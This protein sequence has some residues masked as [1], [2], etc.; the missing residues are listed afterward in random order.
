MRET[1]ILEELRLENLYRNPQRSFSVWDTIL[2]EKL[3]YEP[4]ITLLLNCSCFDAKVSDD[5]IVSVT[6]W[7]TTTQ[8]FHTVYASVFADCSGDAILAPLSGAL[9]RMVRESREEYGESYALP[10]ADSR[11]MGMSCMF[12]AR[13][14]EREVPF[15][16]PSWAY[17]F[18]SCSDLPGGINSHKWLEMGY[19]LLVD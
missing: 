3:R 9:Y 19:W 8:T 12:Q 14:F 1:G 17:K 7:Q 18:D 2:Y 15:I 6:R 16:P 11:T 10:V 13:Q 4:N 5:R